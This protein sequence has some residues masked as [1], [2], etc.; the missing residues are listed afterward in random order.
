MIEACRVKAVVAGHASYLAVLALHELGMPR[1]YRTVFVVGA[2]GLGST[3]Q[4]DQEALVRWPAGRR[5]DL[6]EAAR[7]PKSRRLAFDGAV[8]GLSTRLIDVNPLEQTVR[9][10]LHAERWRDGEL[11][12]QEDHCLDM[13]VYFHNEVLLMLRPAAQ[14]LFAVVCVGGVVVDVDPHVVLLI[15][16]DRVRQ[17]CFTG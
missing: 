15:D 2:F 5:G 4:R 6:P 14:P 13:G 17:D 8:Y 11:E 16:R 7:P 10:A 3:R 12:A 9:M 1:R